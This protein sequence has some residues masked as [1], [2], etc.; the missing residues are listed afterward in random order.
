MK[1]MSKSELANLAGVSPSTFKRWLAGYRKE[2]E[3]MGCTPRMHIL[4]PKCVKFICETFDIDV[5]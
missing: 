1:S 4:P 5:R 2:L 3:S